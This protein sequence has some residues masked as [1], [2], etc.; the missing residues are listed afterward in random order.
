MLFEHTDYRNYLKAE[1]AVRCTKNSKYSLRAFSKVLNINVSQLSR[2]FK[3]KKNIS[4][5]KA[6]KISEVLRLNKQEKEYFCN[7]VIL[8]SVRSAEAKELIEER[9]IEGHP[10]KKFS[11]LEL[12]AFR[13]ISEWY[14]YAILEMTNLKYFKSDSK[15]IAKKLNTSQAEVELA[16]DRLKRLEL[17]EVKKGKWVKVKDT[18]LAASG[19]PNEALRKFHKQ[20]LE[21]AKESIEIQSPQEKNISSLTFAVDVSKLPL[22]QKKIRKFRLEMDKLLGTG[23]KTEVYHLGVQLFRLTQKEE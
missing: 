5:E 4:Y 23:K 19:V 16:I 12:D 11:T 2:V 9:L 13:V 22:A 10:T 18:Y 8:A 7:L 1:L 15:W 17:L 20:T 6:L 14:H 3:G 21:K